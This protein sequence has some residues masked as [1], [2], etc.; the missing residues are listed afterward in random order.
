[1]PRDLSPST[2]LTRPLPLPAELCLAATTLFLWLLGNCFQAR[3]GIS[4]EVLKVVVADAQW[5][6]QWP[7]GPWLLGIVSLAGAYAHHCRSNLAPEERAGLRLRLR[8][9]T[10]LSAALML[11]RFG[12]LLDPLPALLP[13]LSLLW[14]PHATWALATAFL[15]YLHGPLLPALPTRAT[16]WGLLAAG[17]LGF[18]GWSLYFC[19]MTML[20]GDEAHYLRVSQSLL[21]DGDMDLTN[22]VG[23]EPSG[24]FHV[25]DFAPHQAPGSPPG[26]IHSVHPIGLSVLMAPA[27]WAGLHLW[28]NPRLAASLLMA[29]LSAGVVALS[30]VWLVRLGFAPWHALACTLIGATTAPFLLFAPQVYPEIPAL[31]IT[32]VVLVVLAHWQEPESAYRSLGAREPLLLA[33]L[34]VLLVLLVFF[35]PRYLPL[36]LWLAS[37]LVL[38]ARKRSEPRPAWRLLGIVAGVGALAHLAF[39]YAYSNDLYGPFLPGNA[40]EEG[41]LS[42]STWLLSLPGHWLHLTTGLLNSSPVFLAST[43]GLGLLALQPGPRRWGAAAFYLVTAGV[44]GLHPDW[45]FGFCPPARFLLT[46]LPLL[47]LGLALFL[48][49]HGSRL[50]VIFP[51]LFGLTLAY[52]SVLT[53]AAVPEQAFGGNFLSVRKLDEF[54]P[55]DI[56]FFPQNTGDLPWS[57]FGFWLLLSAALIAALLPALPSPWRRGA[58]LGA[59]LLPFAWGQADAYD[60]RLHASIPPYLV[61]LDPAGRLPAGVQYFDR[62]VSNEYQ[63]TTGHTL[64]AGGYGAQTPDDPAGILKSFYAPLMQP[65]VVTYTLSGVFAQHGSGQ[66]AGH[67]SVAQRSVLPAIADWGIYHSQPIANGATPTAEFQL[68][69][70]TDRTGLAYAYVEYA[71]A[72]AL[73]FKEVSTRFL[74]LR[75]EARLTEV[76]D[77][78]GGQTQGQRSSLSVHCAGLARGYYRAR[79]RVEGMPF[80][81]LF[82]RKPTPVYLA[83][84]GEGNTPLGGPP[85]ETQAKR[86]LNGYYAYQDRI[87]RPD[88]VRPLVESIQAPWWA[89]LP[90][91]GGDAYDVEFGLSSAQEIWLLFD[92]HGD[93]NL[94][95]TGLTLYRMDLKSALL[96]N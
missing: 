92:Y 47:L 68:N 91:L 29:L 69:F 39:N 15:L 74:P 87:P 11:F 14:S 23:P 32:L 89:A 61:Q 9:L 53:I 34:G 66:V 64:K 82:Q 17:A 57:E 96:N 55:L 65:G 90:L 33:G 2:R 44:N 27:Y 46:A 80:S 6:P 18:S 94:A 48:Q 63:M 1:M 52:D 43:L 50:A 28:A 76:G 58:L 78:P 16:A 70:P 49:A 21:H 86:W 24:E 62:R 10:L 59:A 20:H 3:I 13:Y 40:W 56:H 4:L 84:Y 35:H 8:H 26:R 22:N 7:L 95:V 73:A 77:F 36:A 88:F 30:F 71:G 19:Q 83:V 81:T 85:L 75:L 37:G 51:L 45:T 5:H 31:L 67:F 42:G 79:F 60:Q 12:T 93:A 54:Y 72:G 25:I 41:A 38:Q